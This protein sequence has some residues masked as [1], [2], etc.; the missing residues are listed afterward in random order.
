MILRALIVLVGLHVFAGVV[1]YSFVMTPRRTDA[2][3]Y[4]LSWLLVSCLCLLDGMLLTA[5]LAEW[6][7][8]G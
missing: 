3:P 4:V 5:L 2:F 1:F 7:V 6:V 8:K